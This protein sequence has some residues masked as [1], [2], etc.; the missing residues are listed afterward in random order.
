MAKTVTRRSLMMATVAAGV[1]AT[2]AIASPALAPPPVKPHSDRLAQRYR[3]EDPDMDL[4]WVAA[5]GWGHAGGL[6]VGQAYY[7]AS[8][9]TDGDPDSWVEAFASYGDL[10][11]EQADVWKKRGWK[12]SSGEMRLKAFASYRS[13]WQFAPLGEVFNSNF[14]KHKVAFASAMQELN[15]PATFFEVAYEGKSLPGVFLQNQVK[16]A[17]VVLVVGGADTCFEEMFFTV[18]RSLFERGYSVAMADLPGQGR[19]PLDGLHWEVQA[20]KPITATVELL[21]ERFKAKPGRMALLGAS[22]GGYFV[23]RA[24]GYEKRFA[25]VIAST[26]VGDTKKIMAARAAEAKSPD[27]RVVGKPALRN[28]E[29]YFWKSG[30]NDKPALARFSGELVADPSLVT[31]PFLSIVGAGESAAAQETAEEWHETIRSKRKEFVKLDASTGADGH[32]QIAN[33]LRLAQESA[34][35]L[36]EIFKA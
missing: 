29:V 3:F 31:V 6:D 13:A 8:K 34:G 35:F 7:V 4:F 2:G 27:A 32:V 18:G 22:L 30:T 1:S 17:P 5:I 11:N 23:C 9:M 12:Q 16:A 15:L 20:E 24:A 26:P 14:E 19:T 25:A 33:R 36:D 21:I 28:Q 10:M